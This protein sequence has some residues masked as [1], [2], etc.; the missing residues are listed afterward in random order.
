MIEFENISEI[1]SDSVEIHCS[2]NLLLCPFHE[3]STTQCG[4]H[5]SNFTRIVILERKPV[6]TCAIYYL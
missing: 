3:F 2:I 1:K 6:V 4:N 5:V